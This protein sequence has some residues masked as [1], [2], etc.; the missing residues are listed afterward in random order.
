MAW[1]VEWVVSRDTIGVLRNML[2]TRSE[3]LAG[4]SLLAYLEA[5]LHGHHRS[6]G[7]SQGFIAELR[8]LVKG[9]KGQ[10][11]L[12]TEKPPPFSSTPGGLQQK[13]APRIF[14]EWHARPRHLSIAIPAAWMIH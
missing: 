12:Y 14:P 11:K 7:P 1:P 8:H 13:C 6:P 9:I 3:E 2:S 4:F 5:L 10:T